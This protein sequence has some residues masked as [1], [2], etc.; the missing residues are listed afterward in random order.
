MNILALNIHG[1][2]EHI[3]RNLN[4]KIVTRLLILVKLMKFHMRAKHIQL[5]VLLVTDAV[6]SYMKFELITLCKWFST[7][8]SRNFAGGTGEA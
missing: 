6:T 5:A 3:G 8:I 2:T 1:K 7:T 4:V